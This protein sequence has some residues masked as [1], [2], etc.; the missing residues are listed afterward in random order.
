MTTDTSTMILDLFRA[1]ETGVLFLLLFL[2]LFSIHL[3]LCLWLL[4]DISFLRPSS[5]NPDPQIT[6]PDFSN[7][8]RPK[9][10]PR[11]SRWISFRFGPSFDSL[12]LF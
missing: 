2:L 9:I 7:P 3:W 6:K 8:R 5:L 4:F 12:F 11:E 10:G 1:D